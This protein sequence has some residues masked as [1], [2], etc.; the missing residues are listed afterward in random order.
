MADTSLELNP[1]SGGSNL[2]TDADAGS[3]LH[4]YVKI[5]F[6][7]SG[8]QT[9]VT[10]AAPLPV[11][12]GENNDVANAG[13][14]VVQEDGA[15]LTAL[16]LIDNIVQVEDAV[17]G[18]GDSG[19]M[20]LAVRRDALV[21]SAAD[22]DYISL[23]TDDLGALW[24]HEEPN[25]VDSGNSST[26]TLIADAVFTGTGVD[27]L[28]Y[29]AVSVQIDSSHDSATDGISLEFSIDN[30]NWDVARNFSYIAA[31]NGAV[32]QL[33]THSQFFRIVY[34]NG[35][36]GQ[37]T[38]RLE[39]L[40]HHT[41]PITNVSRL[42]NSES[43]ESPAVVNK[44]A[45]IAQAAGTGDFVPVQATT[46]G[47]L[48]VSIEEADT[49][50]SGL[51]KAE[52]A[53]HSSGD[54]GVMTLAVRSDTAVPIAAA[55][56]YH[57][58]LTNDEG[59]LWVHDTPNTVDSGNSTTSTLTA[60]SAFTGTGV[61][62][63]G[64]SAVTIQLDASHDSA[65]DGMSFQL[66]TD[67]TNWDSVHPFTYTAADGAREFQFST[68]AQFF[69]IVYTNGGT[70]QTHLRIQTILHHNTPITTIHRLVDDVDPDR[71]ATMHKSVVFAQTSGSGDFKAIAA[72]AQGK[73]QVGADI[74]GAAIE[75][76]EDT[77]HSTG[78]IGIMPLAVRNDTLASLVD[79]D[80]DYAP[81]QVNATGALYVDG[82][83]VTQPI[84][85]TVTANLSATDNAVL[86]DIA[87]KLAPGESHYRNIDANAEAA[88][89]GSAGTLK[90]LHVMNQT[91]AKA[92]L[93]LY[94]AT[95]ASVTPGSTTPDFTFALPTQGDTNGAGFTL[96]LG[97]Q[98]QAFANA[99]TLVCTTT[100]DGSAGDPGT[101]GVVVNAGYT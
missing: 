41:S 62:V 2:A 94:D 67:N 22:A 10:A 24:V 77:Q 71:S 83:D 16:E 86:D 29:S 30:T 96:P 38:F 34:T 46:A 89:K 70:N 11:D 49:S 47:N 3:E 82:S 91:A 90:W 39:T 23:S 4:Q 57:P 101:N 31:D 81:H 43:A 93:H 99:I 19:V 68:H 84:S 21:A 33:S 55:G 20:A 48:K 60:S 76:I 12:L 36:T 80:G 26:S 73:L 28:G 17:A 66:S 35:S 40:L 15:A 37:T 75:S 44:S 42:S 51:A 56:D 52:D 14:F 58:L 13:T 7:A 53:V 79:T 88:I 65:V 45:I 6:G 50:A 1:G 72:N 8:T 100:L 87:A 27:V 9:P 61:D 59:A 85:G 98:G 95:T 69:R 64:F 5:E 97:G 25:F 54:T 74:D 92:Y 32:F 63:L 78:D 18:S